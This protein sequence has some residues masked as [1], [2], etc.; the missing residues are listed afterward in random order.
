[1]KPRSDLTY[2]YNTMDHIR[3]KQLLKKIRNDL[4][5]ELILIIYEYMT[6]KAKFI[7]NKKYEYLEKNIKNDYKKNYIYVFWKSLNVVFEP[8]SK[9]KTIKYLRNVI[10]PKHPDVINNIWYHS[11]ENGNFY[12]GED[13]LNLWEN[14]A[15]DIIYYTESRNAFNNHIKLRVIDAIYYYILHNITRIARCKK[16]YMTNPLYANSDILDSSEVFRMTDKIHHLCKSIEI[17]SEKN[18]K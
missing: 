2:N 18:T 1:M 5:S 6:G 10:I 14:D 13:L 7:C 11:K 17:L 15:V 3:E 16:A 4:S 8:W 9:E 12:T